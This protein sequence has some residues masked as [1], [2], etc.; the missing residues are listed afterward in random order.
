[1]RVRVDETGQHRGSPEVNDLRAL[2]GGLTA[3]LIDG[4]DAIAANQNVLV[5]AGGGAAAIDER[6]GP[7]DDGACRLWRRRGRIRRSRLLSEGQTSGADRD[8]SQN[9]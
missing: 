4:R 6:T 8:G 3:R 1:M 9:I 2:R 5:R 7:D